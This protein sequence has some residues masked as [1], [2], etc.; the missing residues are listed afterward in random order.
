MT[1]TREVL[2]RHINEVFLE[3]QNTRKIEC[4][5]ITP[6]DA[7]E[8]DR[9]KDL[10]ATHIEKVLDFQS[11]QYNMCATLEVLEDF[12]CYKRGSLVIATDSTET[13]Y[14]IETNGVLVYVP[15]EKCRR[16]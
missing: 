8:L 12:H 10:L 14:I 6:T 9:L 1:Y 13:H 16:I 5:D 11:P 3:C 2:E 7:L 4:G 15:H